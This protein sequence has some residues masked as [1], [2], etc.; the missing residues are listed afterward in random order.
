MIFGQNLI[1][2][3]Y[4]LKEKKCE[5]RKGTEDWREEKPLIAREHYTER[6]LGRV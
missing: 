4:P 2:T 3:N 6:I 1:S 5:G